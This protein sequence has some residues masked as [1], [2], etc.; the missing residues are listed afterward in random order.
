MKNII[1]FA[2]II[3][4]LQ[5]SLVNANENACLGSITNDLLCETL[6][7]QYETGDAS[8]L[9]DKALSLGS[10]VNIYEYLRNNTSYSIYHGAR[11]S[12]LNTFLAME[13]S[14][15]DLAS[16]L[17]ALYRSVGIQ[18]RYV[19]GNVR[20]KRADVSNWLSIENEEL[21]ISVLQNQG[22][23]IVD[24]TDP[25]YVTF[26][27]VWVE[28]LVNFSNYRGGS[29]INSVCESESDQCKWI[30]LDP[31]FKL[32]NYLPEYKDVLENHS[33]DYDAYYHA[34]TNQ[35]LRDKSPLEIFEESS[36]SYLREHNPGITLEDVTDKGEVIK[37]ELG[38]LPSSLPYLV[39]GNVQK[40][41]SIEQH[42]SSDETEF[43]WNKKIT[44]SLKPVV[45]GVECG[46]TLNSIY[47]AV[48][49]STKQLTVNWVTTSG[50]A[51]LSLRLDGVPRDLN[52][53]YNCNG[54][55]GSITE[56]SI[57][58]ITLSVEASP[59][60][61]PIIVK[62]ENLIAG[63]YYLIAT[64]GETSNWSQVRRAYNSLL[65]ANTQYPLLN[66]ASGTVY[67]DGNHDGS[68]DSTDIE[69]LDHPEAQDALT[70]GLLYAAQAL[71][72]TRLKEDSRRYGRLKNIVSPISAFVGI[73]STTHEVE[74]VDGTPFA[75]LPGGLLIDLKGIRLNGSWVTSEPET[76]SNETF[77]FI[78]HLAS[79]LEHEV[80]Q[81]LTGYDA[82][83]TMRGIQFALKDGASLM[84]IRNTSTEDTFEASLTQMGLEH[85]A[86][87]EFIKNEYTLFDRKLVSWEYTGNDPSNAG[88]YLFNG[89]LNTLD[90]SDY[91]SSRYT[92][93]AKDGFDNTVSSYDEFENGIILGLAEEEKEGD[94]RT[95]TYRIG[96]VTGLELRDA[97]LKGS[98]V[99]KFDLISYSKPS[100]DVFEFILKEKS[101][102]PPGT[103]DI[104]IQF[105]YSNGGSLS[106]Y[107]ANTSYTLVDRTRTFTCNGNSYVNERLSQTL[108]L[109]K[110]CFESVDVVYKD[111]LDMK[112]G[113]NPSSVF[114]KNKTHSI[115]DY[116]I[117]FVEDVR[118]HMY[119]APEGVRFNFTAPSRLTS[120]PFFLFEVYIKDKITTENENIV[121]S[122]YIIRNQSSRIGGGGGYVPE[123]VPIEP[124]TDT[125]GVEGAGTELDATGVTFNNE[126]FTDQNL[127]AI[128]N[129][130]VIRTPSTVDPV[131]TVTGNMYHDETDIVIPGKGLSYA[132]T[133][134]YNSN[135]TST[136]GLESVNPNFV[137]LSQG[138]THSYNMKLVTNDYGQYPN[139]DATLAPE[140]ENNKTSSITYIDERGGES[141]YLL[142]DS[143][144][145]QPTSPRTGFDDLV[146]N[147]PST[148]L[149]TINYSNGVSYVFDSRGSDIRTPG[150][151]ARLHQINDAY[152]NQLNFSYANN[153]LTRITDNLGL[154][155]R[156]GLTLSYYAS[157]E[158]SGRLQLLSDW[159][160]RQ[161]EYLYTNGKLSSVKNP[162]GD[163]MAYTYVED[164]HWL[165]DIIHP[166]DRNGKQKTMTFGYYENGQAYN[167]VD[168][169][170][171]EES[172]IYD[173]FRRRT[174]VTNPRDLIT[175][176]YY[177]ENGA[178]IKLVQPDKGILLFENNADG[179]RY[180][181]HNALG[182]RTRYSYNTNRS[183]TGL[184][185]DTN[186]QVT[187][188]EDAL[189]YT[190]D[191]SY[192]LNE[193]VTT[194]KD[195]N[196][197]EFTNHYYS[198]ND[199]ATGAVKGKLQKRVAAK[200][201]VNGVLHTNVILSEYTYYSDGTLKNQV[202]YIDPAQPS[203]K[204][205]SAY[206]YSYQT[207][208]SY[209]ATVTV[210]G[211]GQSITTVQSYDSLWRLTA[212]TMQRRTS[213]VDATLI[214]LTTSYEYDDL[215]RV[216]KTTD[217]AGNIAESTFDDNG[218]LSQ[219]II[220]YKLL[221]AGNT[222][223]F[224]ECSIDA[225][226]SNY[227]SCVLQTNSYDAADRL[228]SS[229]DIMGATT[230][231]EYDAMGNVL[232]I[233]NAN[234]NSLRYEYDAK[235]HRTKV[236]NENGYS[237][238]TKYDLAGRVTEVIDANNHSIKYTYD[239]LGRQ[240]T[241]ATHEGRQTHYDKYDANGNIL[242]ITDANAIKGLQPKNNKG[243][244]VATEFD[245]FNR[246]T[247]R[248]NANNEVTQYTYDLLG[249]RTSLTDAK[250]QTT[251]FIYDDLVRLTQIIDPI[252]ETGSDKVVNITYDEVGNR[253]TYSD[254]LGEVTRYSYD[255]LNRLIK[256]EYLT[257]GIT[258][259]KTY[260]QYGD[261]TSASYGTSVYQYTYDA[262]H[263]LRS[264]TDSR[265]D[266]SMTWQYD[267]VGNVIRKTN[268]QN[269]VQKFVYD[270]TNRLVSMSVGEPIILQASYHYDP[271]GRLLSR[272][273]SNGAATLYNY[274]ADG[275][276][277]SIKQVGADGQ[278]LDQREYQ[279]DEVGNI[280]QVTINNSEIID[281]GYDPAYRLLTAESNE[282]IH[283]L[284]YSYDAVGNRLT[285]TANGSEQHYIYG[286]ANRLD[287]VRLNSTTGSQV[288]RFEYD[289]N[290]SMVKKY[291]NND[292]PLMN[293][294]YD[295]RRLA[296]VM[297]VS[298][299]ANDLAFQYDA[300][301]YRIEKENST[302]TKKYFLEGEHLES[303]Y[304]EDDELQANYLRGVVVDEVISGFEKNS[305]DVM[306]S[307]TFH[308]DQV[309]S[310]T[311]LSDHN[312][313]SVQT[314]SYG[315]FGETFSTSGSSQNS[316][317]Y[318][319]RE[320][321]DETGL[322]YYR[323]R[324]YD[325]ELGRFISEDPIGFKGGINFYVY[326]NNRPLF[327]RDPAGFGPVK[328]ATDPL[329]EG[330]EL[331][332]DYLRQLGV[333]RAREQEIDLIQ[334]GGT[335]TR[336]WTDEQLDMLNDG[337]F[338]KDI[339]G[340]HCNS[341]ACNPEMAG[342]PDN[343]VF[344]DYKEHLDAHD[345]NW[346]NQ[347]TG[348]LVDRT[349]AGFE[350]GFADVGLL[351]G[352]AAVAI[353]G[354]EII[355]WGLGVVEQFDPTFIGTLADG[356]CGPGA[357]SSNASGGFLIYPNKV[358][359]NMSQAVYS[360]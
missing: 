168:Q 250:N 185:S 29:E 143:I 349:G 142:D 187:R 264:K 49:L 80:W 129:N 158:N 230:Q 300:N 357:C 136:D 166:Q 323:A 27:H 145:S 77:K 223:L 3:L 213:A 325:P 46:I 296:S 308:H 265:N 153:Q 191:Y 243:S 252:I 173:L 347:T 69:L 237:I 169:N 53:N 159:S 79:A 354:L 210:T 263:R 115:L 219:A 319:G 270:S 8:V 20:L 328:L 258:A 7:V 121:S 320:L 4:G 176:H 175:E 358:N 64:G 73:V 1:L 17:I 160:G 167:Y 105:V 55:S 198:A 324:Y 113:F 286:A 66:N 295:Q 132:F 353:S 199:A 161:W 31:S 22:T 14:D 51:N 135:E 318:T 91:R 197:N 140:N 170:A 146:L 83:S 131:S 216:I 147:S 127:I 260:D 5:S 257:D 123:G 190:I 335:G 75:V 330:V 299:P 245:E 6:E 57:F 165:K 114:Y 246:L 186:G 322:Y 130:D 162:L 289:A 32:R 38:L 214:D 192:G 164:T 201:T 261:M 350:S 238:K 269:E 306:E 273:L 339:Y 352:L 96:G 72:Y 43:N 156:T 346:Q 133:R 109:L 149:H 184:A 18:S 178:L 107:T 248:L 275:F 84:D 193:Q 194:I 48:E 111:F 217:T 152:G 101:H 259:E 196:G 13:G 125:E 45:D 211:S 189:G 94:R 99:D 47:S 343:V 58:N 141:N 183:L 244:S 10:A 267:I 59:F 148:G 85:K 287:A 342:N 71:Y 23:T 30:A 262:A 87:A 208:G 280:T 82:V 182:Q 100:S 344:L 285:K 95:L 203:R 90:N 163:S 227:H 204:R 348:P 78:G 36:L 171:S 309:N 11:S 241:M 331:T 63:G 218:K 76:Y 103:Y 305:N 236:T 251:R 179:L 316:M 93:N 220:R 303:V 317:Q 34:E 157:G 2:F 19:V 272:I 206:V 200:A 39:V 108:I 293:I 249:N 345:G 221:T 9:K 360:K 188:E 304:N 61:D 351:G 302:D 74:L 81:E 312:G 70:G 224:P 276:L 355:D 40:F 12:S 154:A 332:I 310:V 120:G 256:E 334:N 337:I 336:N 333:K 180:I 268:Y 205:V 239:Q 240:L 139:Y 60:T 52:L 340:H 338:P 341:V 174:R 24:S 28:A 283:D 291:D 25:D 284:T 222:A 112:K 128:G 253:L 359:R 212:A 150:V 235:G 54:N 137:P 35:L 290:G 234:H 271:A 314:N 144:S 104:T 281:Y 44:V 326:V 233:T 126:V 172:L 207:D 50:G 102:N 86:P 177:D 195:K 110:N 321:D 294:V 266:L 247:S 298:N 151:A 282:N 33:F 41:T 202:N 117:N 242:K 67:V 315:P 231:Y 68:I 16:A 356:T 98:N 122:E 56:T 307:R 274:S 65:D 134:T 37:E 254:R 106:S 15:V 279:Q 292:Q 229:T 313:A 155:G 116:D 297:N 181:K 228:L 277:V 42:D 92:Y 329:R 301:I 118:N 119:G 88:F 311:S 138:W 226:Y 327:D 62:Y 97:A 215:G 124:A 255:K 225:A 26:E 278:V 89:S 21:V 209:N 232:K 288:Y